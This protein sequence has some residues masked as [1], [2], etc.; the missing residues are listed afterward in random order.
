MATQTT[1]HR[2]RRRAAAGGNERHRH[3]VLVPGVLLAALLWLVGPITVRAAECNRA[4][5]IPVTHVTLPGSP[6]T[7]LPSADGCWLFVSLETSTAHP[8]VA[9]LA[10]GDG[11]VTLKRT[12][13]LPGSPAGMVLTHDGT[14]LIVANGANVVFLDVGRLTTG[15][16][17]PLLG[18]WAEGHDQPMSIYVSV[19]ADD[20]YLLVSN[21]AVGTVSVIDLAQTRRSRFA[22]VGLVG[23]IPVGDGPVGLA[24]S[25][26]ERFLFA[27][28]QSVNAIGWSNQCKPEGSQTTVADHPEGA[29]VVIDMKLA[30]SDAGKSVLRRVPAGCNPVRVVASRQTGRVYVTARGSDK[31]LAFTE[32]ELTG[33]SADPRATQVTVGAS[34][35]GV[36]V[37]DNGRRV[38]VASSDRFNTRAPAPSLY[39]IDS[40]RLVVNTTPIVG[41]IPSRGFPRE[42]RATADGHTLLVTNCSASTLQIVDLSRTS[43]DFALNEGRSSGWLSRLHATLLAWNPLA[44]Q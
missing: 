5:T 32:R 41:V 1:A 19:T 38:V 9:V 36:A 24:L 6:F 20:R 28:V 39:V 18:Y 12:L 14:V 3:R 17:N 43:S 16:G 33:S 31:L 30:A 25:S 23:S 22:Q 42:I 7:A 11:T 15:A 27:T 2:E 35:I 10:R 8:G 37:I 40:A 34:P 4:M 21:E 44:P 13:A 26:D 29:I